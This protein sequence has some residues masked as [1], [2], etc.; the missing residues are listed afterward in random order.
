MN[1][2][3]LTEKQLKAA[4]QYILLRSAR[5]NVA[6]PHKAQMV[7]LTWEQLMMLVAEYGA[8]RAESVQNGG[9]VDEPGEVYR[10]GKET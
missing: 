9:S 6:T 8:I 10:T 7:T 5:G 4:E 1:S 2:S 3:K